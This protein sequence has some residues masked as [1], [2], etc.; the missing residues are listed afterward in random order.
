MFVLVDP[1]QVTHCGNLRTSRLLSIDVDEDLG[2]NVLDKIIL[3]LWI[4]LDVDVSRS[5]WHVVADERWLGWL[6]SDRVKI[7]NGLIKLFWQ[8]YRSLCF[9][10]NF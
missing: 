1:L 5:S 10:L 2:S 7:I 6:L 8:I 3:H 9:I 4:L